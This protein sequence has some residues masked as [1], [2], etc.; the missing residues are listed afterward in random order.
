MLAREALRISVK[1]FGTD[2][3]IM[4]ATYDLLAKIL[5]ERGKFR[6]ET[7]EIFKRALAVSLRNQGRNVSNTEVGNKKIGS[8]YV[9]LAG[10]QLTIVSKK[11]A[12]KSSKFSLRGGVNN[13]SKDIWS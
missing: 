4:G 5:Q 3:Q 7:R 10:I 12:V 8:F 6:D 13:L 2:E 9:G 11:G 1:V